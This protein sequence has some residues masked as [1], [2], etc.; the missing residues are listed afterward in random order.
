MFN[1]EPYSRACLSEKVPSRT[2]WEA[3]DPINPYGNPLETPLEEGS[4]ALVMDFWTVVI[5]CSDLFKMKLVKEI[6]FD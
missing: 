1:V 2:F 3:K 6:K 5:I 4:D